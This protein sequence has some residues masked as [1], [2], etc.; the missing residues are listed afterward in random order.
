VR[1]SEFPYVVNIAVPEGSLRGMVAMYDFHT[2]LGIMPH[3][4]RFKNEDGRR[5]FRWRFASL[6]TAEKFAREFGGSVVMER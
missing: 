5:Y 6:A 2:R 3:R 1:W 4:G